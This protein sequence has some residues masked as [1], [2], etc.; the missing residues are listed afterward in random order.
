M[1][2]FKGTKPRLFEHI[3]AQQQIKPVVKQDNSIPLVDSWK[4]T[5]EDKIFRTCKGVLVLPVSRFYGVD[6]SENESLDRFILASKRCY[7]G[8]KMLFHLPHYMNYFEKY[9]D[10]DKELL[11]NLFRIKYLL[12]YEEDYSEEMF[13]DDLKIYFMGASLINKAWSMNEYNYMLD[14][15]NKNYHNDKNPSLLYTDK[16]AKIMMW[17]S[18]MINM[19]IPAITHFI[20]MKDVK[21]SN[22]FLLRI[23]DILLQYINNTMGVNIYGKLYD[24]AASN[25]ARNLKDNP[26]LWEMQNIRGVNTTTHTISSVNNILLNI[27]PKYKYNANLISLNYSSI[28][29]NISYQIDV[30][31]DYNFIPLSG[32]KRDID[33]NSEWDKFES[34]Q[35]RAN[36]ALHLQNEANAHTTMRS[37]E[38]AYGPFRQ[39]EIDF[40]K[41]RLK[42]DNGEIINGFQK[43]LIFNLFYKNFGVPMSAYSIN[44]DDYV[45]L[46]IAAKRML[47]ANNMVIL[48]YVISSKIERLQL[49]KSINKKEFSKIELSP[50]YQQIIDKYKNPKIEKYIL[51]LIATILTSEFRIIDYDDPEIDGKKIAN[52]PDIISEEIM[53]YVDMI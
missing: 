15:D 30:G 47:I 26:I 29:I 20:Y 31:Y 33:Q 18:L 39:E 17:L 52:I 8:T 45:K 37:I 25:I 35:T 43:N 22:E 4:P 1:K 5:K 28:R 27:I 53:M 24:T 2:I 6:P 12:D 23:Y 3:D 40:Y 49:K 21:D 10:P 7:N 36:E 19:M 11:I 16:H 51:S 48:P 46:L 9:F 41:E 44:K 34:L 42:N 38:Y 32:S 13:I 14:L 50:Y